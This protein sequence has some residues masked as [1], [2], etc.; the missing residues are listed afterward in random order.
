[1]LEA[2]SLTDEIISPKMKVLLA[3]DDSSIRRFIEIILQRADYEVLTAEDGL[4]AMKMA[5]SNTVDAII[6]DAMMPNLGGYD[7]C[8]LL[9]QNHLYKNI[10]FVI[11]S[12]TQ[13]E[14]FSGNDIQIDAYVLKGNNLKERLTETLSQLLVKKATV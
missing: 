11:L 8:R 9:R 14:K 2:D 12:G 7:L 3:E 13:P 10:P 1:M 5:L 4:S 6:A